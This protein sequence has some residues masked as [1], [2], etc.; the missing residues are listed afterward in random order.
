MWY[1]IIGDIMK[2][3]I[4]IGGGEN[5]R[6][7][8]PYETYEIDKEIV[9]LSQKE[10]PTVLFI[11][12]ASLDSESY[13]ETMK[14]IFSKLGC[15]VNNLSL[16]KQTYTIEELKNILERTDIV[17]VGGGNTKELLETWKST[18]LD[19]LLDEASEK[20][21]VLSGLSAG[22]LCWFSYCNSDS[23]KYEEGSNE[24]ICKD[25]LGFIDAVNCPHYDKEDDRKQELKRM[26][27]NLSNHIA[28][29]LDNCA[30][31][32]IVGDSYRIISSKDSANA[33]KTYWIGET[34]FEEKLPKSEEYSSLSELLKK[35]LRQK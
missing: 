29:A 27:K 13:Y 23:L 28:I 34:Y 17:Y 19:K 4:A 5:G 20:G 8:Y 35:T 2:K 15:V 6:P 22:S 11:G 9:S 24:L 26:M 32:E 3:I 33:Y 30:A 14:K 1:N 10:N 31:I 21:L 18:G 12:T 7:G 25:G 16:T